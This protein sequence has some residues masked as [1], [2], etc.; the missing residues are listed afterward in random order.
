ME[1]LVAKPFDIET[2]VA[3]RNAR[4]SRPIRPV[5]SFTNLANATNEALLE[6]CALGASEETQQTLLK[7]HIIN[8]VTAIE[9]YYKDIL[10]SVFRVCK[11]SAFVDK[12]AKL[13]DSSYRIGDLVEMHVAS[14]HPLE[15]IASNQSFQ[16]IKSIDTVFTTLIGVPFWKQAKT[17]Q[18]RMP[19]V[20]GETVH[21]TTHDQIEDMSAL[22]RL[23]H[24]LIHNPSAQ[25][26][27]NKDEVGRQID[28]VCAV[29][30]ASDILINNWMI[31]NIDPELN[32]EAKAERIK[33]YQGTKV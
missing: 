21:K 20:T 25:W 8:T 17:L 30:L 26:I 6:V 5:T 16:N 19:E 22:F 9:V 12:L 15:L 28:S 14:V 10:D 32:E 4:S 13:H 1:N 3:N 2:L 24:Q 33:K 31:E 27:L 29:I 7:S 18:Y 23:R 11:S